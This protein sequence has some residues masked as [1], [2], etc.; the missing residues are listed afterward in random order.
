MNP[1]SSPTPSAPHAPSAW[2]RVLAAYRRLRGSPWIV[3]VAGT[4]RH[5]FTDADWL[6]LDATIMLRTLATMALGRGQ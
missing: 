3:A 2:Q 4:P 5:R 6:R 1:T